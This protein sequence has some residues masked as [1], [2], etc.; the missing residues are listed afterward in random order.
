MAWMRAWVAV[1]ALS[2]MAGP[3]AAD[4]LTDCLRTPEPICLAGLATDAAR[5]ME[6]PQLG[7]L[8]L[9]TLAIQQAMAGD[10]AGAR[11]TMNAAQARSLQISMA[12]DRDMV[13]V[14]LAAGYAIAGDL[15][16]A[17]GQATAIQEP[18]DGDEAMAAIVR[19]ALRRGDV[20]LAEHLLGSVGRNRMGSSR[21]LLAQAYGLAGDWDKA[22]AVAQGLLPRERG[23]TAVWMAGTLAEQGRADEAA[24][25]ALALVDGEDVDAALAAIAV[26]M[27]NRGDLNGAYYMAEGIPTAEA[28]DTALAALVGAFARAGDFIAAEQRAAGIANAAARRGVLALIAGAEAR[29]GDAAGAL[30]FAGAGPDRMDRTQRLRAVALA[31]AAAGDGVAA[32]AAAARV[33]DVDRAAVLAEVA[34]VLLDAGDAAGARRALDRLTAEP[35]F[36]RANAGVVRAAVT[37]YG[38]LGDGDRAIAIAQALPDGT[39]RAEAF[40][41]AAPAAALTAPGVARRFV[42]LAEAAVVHGAARGPG[43]GLDNETAQRR[44]AIVL[45]RLGDAAEA[46]AVLNDLQPEARFQALMELLAAAQ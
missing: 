15:I 30:A 38:R 3:A 29:G 34:G 43:Q 6:Q 36:A 28:R 35:A 27:A 13:R 9:S 2:G 39:A 22:A 40:L 16:A 32:L 33:E 18:T 37:D 8:S 5:A 4:E 25:R 24:Q 21:V 14:W 31:Q 7:V 46:A 45:V 44:L 1:A 19:G 12:D 26:A 10:V 42:I 23:R 20:A 41:D 11:A 17:Q